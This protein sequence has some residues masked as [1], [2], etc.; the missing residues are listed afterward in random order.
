MYLC[1]KFDNALCGVRFDTGT[2]GTIINA[3]Q[4]LSTG[5]CWRRATCP[6]DQPD[7]HN[8]GNGELPPDAGGRP[9][10]R[11]RCP[12]TRRARSATPTA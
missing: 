12:R 5:T 6:A 7:D 9:A 1:H 11:V 4:F 3:G 10:R 8:P 2:M